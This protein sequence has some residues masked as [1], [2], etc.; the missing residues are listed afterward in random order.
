MLGALVCS[1]LTHKGLPAWS[2]RIAFALSG[3]GALTV[4]FLRKSVRETPLFIQAQKCVGAS[5]A[6]IWQALVQHPRAMFCTLGIACFAG[7]LSFGVYVYSGTYLHIYA[8]MPLA[9]AIRYVT[10]A[11]LVDVVVEPFAALVADRVGKRRVMMVGAI[12]MLIALPFLIDG[13]SSSS[14]EV[15]LVSLLL[16][17]L[18]IAISMAPS[19]AIMALMFP[20]KSRYSGFGFS[21]NVGMSLFGGTTPLMLA[22]L[23]HYFHVPLAMA[24]Y[25]MLA[26]LVGILALLYS[27]GQDIQIKS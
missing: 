24:A 5:L 23:L 8:H 1:W 6:H 4:V 11:L 19:N 10:Y 21:F 22:L 25:F 26:T 14:N 2:W 18:L 17:S 20:V 27:V 3:F 7:V 13:F 16:T 15:M 12:L 9:L